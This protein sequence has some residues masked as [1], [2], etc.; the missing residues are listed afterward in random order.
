MVDEVLQALESLGYGRSEVYPLI[1][2]LKQNGEL[3]DRVEEN[4]RK[5]LKYKARQ[6]K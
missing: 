3:S 4:L 2:D 6:M 5:V 1:L